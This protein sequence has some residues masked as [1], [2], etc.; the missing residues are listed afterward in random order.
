MKKLSFDWKVTDNYIDFDEPDTEK[1]I[2]A[3]I[4][5]I[6]RFKAKDF[7]GTKY[8]VRMQLKPV[9]GKF[10]DKWMSIGLFATDEEKEF[11][12][13]EF[14]ESFIGVGDYSFGFNVQFELFRE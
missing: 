7:V 4:V 6:G 11:I 1:A 9:L 3:E 13:Y 8:D 14:A 10:Y 5:E 12:E 2:K